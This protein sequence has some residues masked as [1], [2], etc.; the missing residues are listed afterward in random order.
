MKMEVKK[1]ARP[2]NNESIVWNDSNRKA[3]Y[4]TMDLTNYFNDAFFHK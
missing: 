4:G 3:S 1:E 2:S